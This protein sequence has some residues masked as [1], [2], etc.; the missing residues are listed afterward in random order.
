MLSVF[1]GGTIARYS[2]QHV[3][4]RLALDDA[5]PVKDYVTAFKRAF[6]GTDDDLRAGT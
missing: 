2:G 1:I 6:L 5:Y 3:H 4:R